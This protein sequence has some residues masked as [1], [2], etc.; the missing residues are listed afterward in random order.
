MESTVTKVRENVFV[1]LQVGEDLSSNN[2]E[3]IVKCCFHF[4][5]SGSK[6][7]IARVGLSLIQLSM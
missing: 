7:R 5:L 2:L 4:V 3:I 1:G 6:G